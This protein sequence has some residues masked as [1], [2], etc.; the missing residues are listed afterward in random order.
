MLLTYFFIYDNKIE[1]KG[2]DEEGKNFKGKTSTTGMNK[3][4]TWS[5][6]PTNGYSQKG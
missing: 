1:G 4:Q 3:L 5:P 6:R 2:R